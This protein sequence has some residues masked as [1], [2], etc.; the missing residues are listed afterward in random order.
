VVAI[1]GPIP[2]H[3]RGRS[4]RRYLSLLLS[5]AIAAGLLMVVR[6]LLPAPQSQQPPA[7]API[8]EGA[9]PPTPGAAATPKPT[10]RQTTVPP[11]RATVLVRSVGGLPPG[12]PQ[13][14]AG[15]AGVDR[16]A[17]VQSATVLLTG[18][19]DAQGRPVTGP[20]GAGQPGWGIPVEVAGIDAAGYAALLP[21]P[22]RASIAGLASGEALLGSTSARL[23]GLGRG[24]VLDFAG[25][26]L[27]VAGTVDDA[28]VGAAEVVVGVADA[29][30]LSIR[31]PSYVLAQGAEP[32]VTLRQRVTT[33]LAGVKGVL[34]RDLGPPPWPVSWREV[35]PLALVK[36]RFGEFAV[37]PGIGTAVELEPDWLEA[38]IRTES[39]PLLGRVRCH[40]AMLPALRA[41]LAELQRRGL[42]RLVDP[43]DVAGCFSFRRIAGTAAVSR[44]AWGIAVDLN[45]SRNPYGAQSQQDPRLVEVME[46]HGFAFGGRWPVPDAMHFE[47]RGR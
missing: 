34:V 15:A 43:G 42:G 11:G 8:T 25:R 44:H 16:T 24:A 45:A 5:L 3:P 13:R 12:V 2:R 4:V 47:Y 17:I 30:A 38:Q 18:S 41:A 37:R 9:H 28:L 19:R 26:R 6:W 39:V 40:R 36:D 23:R 33:A 10:S 21:E 27:R 7:S 20:D 35:L 22:E 14:V 31:E 29:A 32:A 1:L 46:R